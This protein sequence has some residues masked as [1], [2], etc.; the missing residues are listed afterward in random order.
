MAR[1]VRSTSTDQF[2]TYDASVIPSLIA[3]F[4][5]FFLLNHNIEIVIAATIR[6]VDTFAAFE[7]A[8]GV[9][10][11]PVLSAIHI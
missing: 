5:E 2:Q 8:C 1:V 11:C 7:S 10:I 9:W 6:N 4:R 3:T